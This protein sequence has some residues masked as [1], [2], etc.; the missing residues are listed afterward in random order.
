MLQ[1]M[2][3]QT[4]RQ[5]RL[6]DEIPYNRYYDPNFFTTQSFKSNMKWLSDQTYHLSTED[7]HP[8]EKGHQYILESF[9]VMKQSQTQVMSSDIIYDGDIWK[10]EFVYD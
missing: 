5:Q 1:E 10:T 8:N 3:Y 6:I 9:L 7:T 2:K 4:E